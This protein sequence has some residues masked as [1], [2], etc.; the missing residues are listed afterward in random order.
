MDGSIDVLDL[1]GFV[2]VFLGLVSLYSR[3][4]HIDSICCAC[5]HEVM[6]VMIKRETL[7]DD[8]QGFY[9]DVS[10]TASYLFFA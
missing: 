5:F 3:F 9:L 6:T 7:A 10:P 4:S 1:N 2:Q 8:R